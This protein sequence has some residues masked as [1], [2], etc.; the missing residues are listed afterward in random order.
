MRQW[1]FMSPSPER[2]IREFGS[3]ARWP[4][5]AVLALAL[6]ACARVESSGKAW[7]H[8]VDFE[9]PLQLAAGIER[10]AS[11]EADILGRGYRS[12]GRGSHTESGPSIEGA[13]RKTLWFRGSA[14][15][16]SDVEIEIWS[17]DRLRPDDREI[18]VRVAAEVPL[19]PAGDAAWHELVD[20]VRGYVV[21][22]R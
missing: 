3:P 19:T 11:L 21:P 18:G 10:L 7:G 4:I 1:E 6:A 16:L 5:A 12:A 20:W 13:E 17:W 22:P 8:T 15:E 14:G 9:T 2:T